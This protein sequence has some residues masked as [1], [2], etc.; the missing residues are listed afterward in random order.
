MDS[1]IISLRDRLF[2][3]QITRREF[4]RG[5]AA[6][7][8][9][10]ASGSL[11]RTAKADSKPVFFGWA[12]YDDPGLWDAYMEKH[13]ELPDFSFWGDEEEGIA[14]CLAGFQPDVLFPCNYKIKKWYKGGIVQPIDVGRLSHWNDVL[15][16]LKNI[17]GT[18]VGGERIWVPV[19]WGL[20]SIIYRTDLAPEY[21]GNESYEILWDPKYKG[22]IGVFD[23]LVDGVAIAAILAGVK[24]PFDYRDPA[25]LD[26][27]RAKMKELVVNVRYFSN[28]VTSLE[29][30]L[31]S[32]ELVAAT[33]WNESIV[34]LRE[35]GLPVGWMNPKE[36]AM[37]WVCGLSIGAHTEVF[38]LA[39]DVIDAF[40][41]PRSRYYEMTAFGYGG[42]TQS[43]FDMIDEE[44]LTAL[45]L[46]KNPDDVLKNG[47]YQQSIQN[48]EGLQMMF[49]EVKAGF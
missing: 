20:T 19:D 39:H 22:K 14:K 37:T 40:L 1:H 15:E 11:V 33:T 5:V 6:A 8:I 7:G 4:A 29:Q 26:A 42:S 34:R 17:D 35:Q 10:A 28:D 46:S 31:A 41:D 25:D 32:G 3:G 18:V 21:V 48:E 43:G 13:G 44:T 47:I 45:G 23:S 16:G 38:D 24:N 9:V 49:D 12:G 36:G 27:T 30:G 2:A